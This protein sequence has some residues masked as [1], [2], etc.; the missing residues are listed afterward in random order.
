MSAWRSAKQMNKEE[1][2][3]VCASTQWVDAN[4]T[5]TGFLYARNWPSRY[6]PAI[7]KVFLPEVANHAP[8]GVRELFT[9][10]LAVMFIA[11]LMIVSQTL[12][13]ARTN[14]A[15]VLKAE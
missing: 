5:Y 11:L 10:V 7:D 4:K 12:K 14:P 8:M 2:N 13:V 6:L 3:L 15:E 1:R 9:G